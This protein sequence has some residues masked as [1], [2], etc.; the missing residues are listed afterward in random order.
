[1]AKKVTL[2]PALIDE[3]K[4]GS[5]LDRQ[6]P[7]LAIQVLGSGK[8]RW[9]YRRAVAGT[10]VVATL[11]GGPFPT[12]S[13]AHAREWA[14]G[15]NEKA[16]AGIDPREA[17]RDEERRSGMTVAR[18][19][20]LY[21]DAVREG[22]SSRAKRPNKPRTIA[23]KLEIYN[24]DIAPKLAARSVYEVS[25]ADLIRLVE[26]KGK[27]A[28]I[29]ANRLAA[30]LKVFFGWA[31]SLRG[32]E[33]GLEAE[34]PIAPSMRALWYTKR[35][36]GD[37]TTVSTASGSVVPSIGAPPPARWVASPVS[38]SATYQSSE[39]VFRAIEARSMRKT[40]LRPLGEAD[41]LVMSATS[42]SSGMLG[43]AA[44]GTAAAA[45]IAT[46]SA[47]I[48]RRRCPERFTS[49]SAAGSI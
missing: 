16:E 39:Y 35:S 4:N 19:H 8:K 12:Q 33:V 7:G 41:R 32:L 11:F 49:F 29:R 3:L 22:R 17:L 46:R 37:H 27:T 42:T 38:R 15:L 13:I 44:A 1:M 36:S 14:R 20:E 18:A 26:R 31:A 47:R 9:F 34:M 28:K 45:R 21:M 2:T 30:E 5:L 6:T 40:T 23:D 10:K 48:A 25:E 43:P 24:R